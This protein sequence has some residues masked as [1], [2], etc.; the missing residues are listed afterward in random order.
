MRLIDKIDIKPL[1]NAYLF[2][3]TPMYLYRHFRRNTS[4]KELAEN[5]PTQRL[6]DEY[7][8]RTDKKTKSTKDIAIAYSILIA[9]TFLEYKQALA[10]FDTINLSRLDWGNDIKDIYNSKIKITNIIRLC[11]EP[12]I[13]HVEQTQSDS[14]TSTLLLNIH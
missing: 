2:A 10:A 5:N 3:N 6:V 7:N 1:T 4:L 14:S 8:R 13:S 11:V 12:R 9:I